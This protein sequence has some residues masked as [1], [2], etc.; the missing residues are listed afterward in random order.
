[1]NHWVR[2]RRLLGWLS[3]DGPEQPEP[4]A[5]CDDDE[6][7]RLDGDLESLRAALLRLPTRF[8][9]V[10]ALRYV[11]GLEVDEVARVLALPLGTVHS[12]LS[13][14]RERLRR[15]LHRSSQP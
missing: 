3:L 7:D 5:R 9:T 15:E 8:Q 2:R 14:G 12:R 4:P 13:R 11:E 1:V 10:L 6:R